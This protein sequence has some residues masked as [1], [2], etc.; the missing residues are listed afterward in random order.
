MSMSPDTVHV[1][2][3]TLN[4]TVGDWSGNLDRAREAIRRARK[5]GV[6]FLVLPEMCLSGYSIEDRLLMRGTVKR[7]WAALEALP[8]RY[9]EDLSGLLPLIGIT[10]GPPAGSGGLAELR[11]TPD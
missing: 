4:Q 5:L 6:T 3:A 7:S 2:V 9:V 11:N 10:G 8:H 1:A